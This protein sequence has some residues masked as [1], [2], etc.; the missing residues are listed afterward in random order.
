A[1]CDRTGYAHIELTWTGPATVRVTMDDPSLEWT[2]T[3]SSTRF[4]DLLNAVSN[5]LPT[6]SWRPRS[7]IRA[8]ERLARSLGMGKIQLAGAMPSGHTGTLMPKQM[9][10]IDESRA[11]LAGMDI[12]HPTHLELN[13]K[14]GAFPLPARGML[15]IGGGVWEIFDPVEYE[16]TR[17]E[18]SASG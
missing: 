1:A 12:G 5:I 9:Y 18:A 14:I 8:R 4:L 3:A 13:P 15:V 2:L 16:R 10:V 6:A 7:L 17:S 11:L